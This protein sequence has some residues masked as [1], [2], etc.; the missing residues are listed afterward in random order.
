ML[1]Y[2]RRIWVGAL[3][4]MFGITFVSISETIA[5]DVP[6]DALKAVMEHDMKRVNEMIEKMKNAPDKKLPNQIRSSSLMIALYAQ[7]KIGGKNAGDDKS[8]AGLRDQAIDVAKG[9]KAKKYAQLM[10]LDPKMGN[11]DPTKKVDILKA[12]VFDVYDLMNQ[13]KKA[14]VGGLNIEKDII[15][16]AQK[17]TK[18]DASG[19]AAR[20]LFTADLLEKLEPDGGFN[21]KK[22]EKEWLRTTKL[23]REAATQLS[24]DAKDEK[25]ALATFKKLDSACTACHNT[26]KE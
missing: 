17:G 16:A 4:L 14:D 26:F 18:A 21:P 7:S 2:S 11:G 22:P 10:P 20:V 19:I 6:E 5:A 8:M 25:K 3:A 12:G 15:D 23:M 13:Y 1:A 9:V 24:K